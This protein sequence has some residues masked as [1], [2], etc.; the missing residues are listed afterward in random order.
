MRHVLEL[1]DARCIMLYHSRP[2]SVAM[3]VCDDG[4]KSSVSTSV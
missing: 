1:T 3:D 2:L 4:Q